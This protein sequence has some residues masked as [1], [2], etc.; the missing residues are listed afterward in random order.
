MRKNRQTENTMIKRR[1]VVI[2]SHICP[3]CG[4][5]LEKMIISGRK[6]DYCPR[7]RLIKKFLDSK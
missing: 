3:E 7:C 4:I 2:D 5:G 1:L 6:V